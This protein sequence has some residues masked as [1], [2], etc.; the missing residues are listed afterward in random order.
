M[1]DTNNNQNKEKMYEE[2]YYS[3][4]RFYDNTNMSLGFS[5]WKG[6]LKIY[7]SQNT[8]APGGFPKYDELVYIHMSPAKAKILANGI[9]EL[10]AEGDKSTKLYGVNT[11][12]GEVQGLIACG[13]RN[14]RKYLVIGKVDP[15]GKAVDTQEFEFT[16]DYNFGLVFSNIEKMEFE[17]NYYNN[18]D[19]ESFRD[20][21]EDYAR[22][23][24]GAM[25]YAVADIARYETA[26]N[27]NK[28]M[29][30]QDA[31][32][33][34]KKSSSSAPKGSSS[35]SFF[36]KPAGASSSTAS[37]RGRSTSIDDLDDLD[38]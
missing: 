25:G 11:G 1:G 5:F 33:I 12:S 16:S 20:L 19:I 34:E 30:I 6:M 9:T 38:D 21:L 31:L 13:N 7:I 8:A 24:N 26:K 22:S 37:T 3:R 14:G 29:A 32:G 15:N 18:M 17:R 35:N 28:I 36:N 27:N 4:M 2:N 10:L 23:T